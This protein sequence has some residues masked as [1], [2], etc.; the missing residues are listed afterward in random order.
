VRGRLQVRR[1]CRRPFAGFGQVQEF[2]AQ[3]QQ[4]G[5]AVAGLFKLRPVASKQQDAGNVGG[6]LDLFERQRIAGRDLRTRTAPFGLFRRPHHQAAFRPERLLKSGSRIIADAL[7]FGFHVTR[8]AR[9]QVCELDRH[10][11]WSR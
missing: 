10:R 6:K 2:V 5:N 7:N 11:W 4:P 8:H 1:A 9:N 3:P